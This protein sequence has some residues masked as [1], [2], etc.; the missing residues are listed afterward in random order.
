LAIDSNGHRS[1]D[2][3]RELYIECGENRGQWATELQ[4]PIDTG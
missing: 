4:A 2:Y 3:D 1:A